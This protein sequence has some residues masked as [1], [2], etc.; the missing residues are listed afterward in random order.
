MCISDSAAPCSAKTPS[1]TISDFTGTGVITDE[2]TV[3]ATGSGEAL[4]VELELAVSVVKGRVLDSDGST[5]VSGAVVELQPRGT[6]D[7]RS[8]TTDDSG[9][10]GLFNEPMEAFELIAEDVTGLTGTASAEFIRWGPTDF[11]G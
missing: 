10:F 8:T 1:Q 9:E 3:S 6:F 11:G 4:N 7:M 5:P 2:E